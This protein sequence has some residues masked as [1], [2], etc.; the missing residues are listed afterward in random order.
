MSQY[1]YSKLLIIL[2]SATLQAHHFISPLLANYKHQ[3]LS[4]VKTWCRTVSV[5]RISKNSVVYHLHTHYA[6][7]HCLQTTNTWQ[8]SVSVFQTSN[9]AVV[10]HHH[11]HHHHTLQTQPYNCHI[12]P[13][14]TPELQ[15]PHA[16]DTQYRSVSVIKTFNRSVVQRPQTYPVLNSLT[17]DKLQM[18]Y[19]VN[20]KTWCR[21][22]SV[23]KI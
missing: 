18:C 14:P 2:W 17:T 11:H 1:L 22:V 7:P 4:A 8:R 23:L 3:V 15:T 5:F 13:S 21:S 16:A 12:I 10:C 19:V 20:Y 9:R 6:S